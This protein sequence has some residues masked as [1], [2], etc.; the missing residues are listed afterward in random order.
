MQAVNAMPDLTGTLVAYEGD[1]KAQYSPSFYRMPAVP[2][3]EPLV[4]RLERPLRVRLDYSLNGA[5]LVPS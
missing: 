4:K 5:I 1:A 2:E 3:S